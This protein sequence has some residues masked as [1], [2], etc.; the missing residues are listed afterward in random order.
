M[1]VV[2]ILS[3]VVALGAVGSFYVDSLAP[4]LPTTTICGGLAFSALLFLA[5]LGL[6]GRRMPK[7]AGARA[8]SRYFMFATL[9]GITIA[10]LRGATQAPLTVQDWALYSLQVALPLLLLFVPLRQLLEAV[11]RCCVFFGLLDAAANFAAVGGL[12]E[13]SAYSGR[14]S[15]FEVITRYP[16]F[17]GNTHA[18][19]LVAFIAVVYLSVQLALRPRR[20]TFWFFLA[21]LVLIAVSMQLIDA[22]RYTA[23]ALVGC[24]A[25]LFVRRPRVA[26]LPLL[27]I[28]VSTLLV[29]LTYFSAADDRGNHLRWLLMTGG[30]KRSLDHL[31]TG[32]GLRFQDSYG[33]VADYYV[34]SQAGVTESGIL[35]FAIAFG[36]PTSIAFILAGLFAAGARR[37]TYSAPAVLVAMLTA[38][39]AFGASVG[40][41][42]GAIVFYGCLIYCQNDGVPQRQAIVHRRGGPMSRFVP[43]PDAMRWQRTS[44][45]GPSSATSHP[46]GS[47]IPPAG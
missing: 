36:W 12:I 22:R 7:P 32:D 42:L 17:A 11:C 39:M 38:E 34:L 6:R 25:I 26:P 29:L 31:L 15:D 4:E 2:A 35:D 37:A 33:I 10:T 28:G 16:G 43:R 46:A 27:A 9:L 13:L 18:A 3:W 14:V 19:G 44:G 23:M 40:G 47:G 5:V 21:A 24:G 41:Y 30:W 1:R 20:Q 45:S 8:L